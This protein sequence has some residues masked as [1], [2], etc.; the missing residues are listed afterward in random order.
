M[1]DTKHKVNYR[2]DYLPPEYI[3]S[4]TSLNV[5]LQ[6]DSTIVTSIVQYR[7]NPESDSAT[8]N[9]ILDGEDLSLISIKLDGKILTEK[10]YNLETSSLTIFNVPESFALEIVTEIFPA[11]NSSLNGLYL[12][13]GNYCTQCEAEGFRKITYYLDKPCV[14]AIFTTRIEGNKKD[15]PVLLAN[16]NKV[17]SGDLD[18]GRHYAIWNDPHPKPSYLF[19]LVAGDL[20]SLDETFVTRSGRQ[21]LLQIF[22]EKRNRDKCE[23]AMASLKKAMK[24]DED[25]F[26]LEYDLDIYMIVAVDDFNMG[27]MENKGLNIFNSKYVLALPETATDQDFLGIEGVIAH[28][29]FHN[30]TGNRVTCRDWF[31]LSL[32]EGLTVFRDQEFSADLN[33]R[34]VQRI[35]DVKVVRDYQF[36]EDAS[37]MAHPVR[38]DSY[39][40]INNFYTVTVYNKG[41]EVIRMM[42]TLLGKENFRKGMDIYFDRH[43]GQAVTCED[44][45][46][47]MEA[48]SGIDL[49]QFRNWYCQAGTPTIT[50]TEAWDES[51]QVYS[52]TLSQNCPPTPEKAVKEPF[53]I[54]IKFGL[55]DDKGQEIAIN[56]YNNLLE[57][58]EK[59]Q[60]YS[61]KD[62]KKKPTLSILRDFSAPVKIEISRPREELIFLMQYDND[63]FNRWD[64]AW[65]LANDIILEITEQSRTGKDLFLDPLFSAGFASLLTDSKAD[66]A[67]I[68]QAITLPQ[69]RYLAQQMKMVDVENL[70]IAGNFVKSELARQHRD[71]LKNVYNRL[72]DQGNYTI[73]P[74]SMGNRSLKNA[75]LSFL[76]AINDKDGEIFCANQYKNSNNMTDSI[77]V[78]SAMNDSQIALREILFEDFYQ[79]WRNDPLV[80]DKWF[81]LQANSVSEHC[82]DN[83][84]RLIQ[85]PEF[86]MK[87]P[88]KVRAVLGVFA[89]NNH[90]CFHVADGSGYKFLTKHLMFLDKNNPQIAARLGTAFSSWK[91]YDDARQKLIAVQLDKLLAISGLSK[92]LFEIIS[93][94]R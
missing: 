71:L 48:G 76:M 91:K 90:P 11:Q 15:F 24:W 56:Q 82:L 86:S 47:A 4:T 63:S 44:F 93:K 23:H 6:D 29:Y 5:I 7:K 33:S 12:S 43:D 60:V 57:L 69:E 18:N 34:A 49:R 51:K 37:A 54:P 2:R 67:L 65:T 10:D 58:R 28:E 94:I 42:H 74:E 39:V 22:V 75:V 25:V 14:L 31:Q 68:A 32:K 17:E 8:N 79:K 50:V 27:A 61:F 35:N 84:E 52:I 9:I 89:N 73:D 20:V 41:A 80:M 30:W 45:I 19:A 36:K 53:H 21:V 70:H 40:E 1:P 26:G 81:A 62:L 83:I 88:N 46:L 13:N 92:D 85:C 87:N 78:L 77:A 38:P 16:G 64:A 66:P 59:E 55:L 3:I 72:N